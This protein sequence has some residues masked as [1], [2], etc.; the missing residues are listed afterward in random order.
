MY[1]AHADELVAE[2]SKSNTDLDWSSPVG[3]GAFIVGLML[4]FYL[5]SLTIKTL[6]EVDSKTKKK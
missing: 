1:F 3:L 6:S 2:I 5:F 4:A